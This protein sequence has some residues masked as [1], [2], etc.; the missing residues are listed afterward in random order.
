MWQ[1]TLVCCKG[2]FIY[3]CENK[4]ADILLLQRCMLRAVHDPANQVSHTLGD[5]DLIVLS[6]L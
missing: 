1:K 6:V 3:P 5:D 4:N 2:G